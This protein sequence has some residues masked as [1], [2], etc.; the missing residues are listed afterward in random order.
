MC[1]RDRSSWR[2]DTELDPFLFWSSS[3]NNYLERFEPSIKRASVYPFKDKKP[4]KVFY[5]TA[6]EKKVLKSVHLFKTEYWV[7]H[8]GHSSDLFTTI[9]RW[10]DVDKRGRSFCFHPLKNSQQVRSVA[11]IP[12]DVLNYQKNQ[13]K[14]EFFHKLK[15]CSKEK[16]IFWNIAK[17]VNQQLI[18]FSE[19]KINAMT[20]AWNASKE[21][22]LSEQRSKAF[23]LQSLGIK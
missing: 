4:S 15:N 13:D 3:F 5:L 21:I 9:L 6:E 20:P 10:E 23:L 1:I 12:K 18:G 17:W 11:S 2:A 19:E 14:F 16:E 8:N 7:H 22:F